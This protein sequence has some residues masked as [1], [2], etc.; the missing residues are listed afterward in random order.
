MPAEFHFLRP[1]WFFALPLILLIWPL[2]R[3]AIQSATSWERAIDPRLLAH[4]LDRASARPSKAPLWLIPPAW[5][6]AITALAGPVWQQLPQPVQE[7]QD[8]LVILLDL[9]LSMLATDVQ[10]NRLTAARRKLR[11]L[12]ET[13]D[14]G[15]TGLIVYAGDP[16]TVS[17]LSD[18]ANTIVNMLPALDPSIMPVPGSRL[19]P[20]ISLASEL[21]RGGGAQTGRI[22]VMTDEIRDVVDAA[23]ATGGHAISVLGIGTAT[24]API[25]LAEGDLKDNQGVMV[26]PT[27]DPS[28]LRRFVD[29]TGGRFATMTLGDADL[30]YLLA[31]NDVIDDSFRDIDRDF[32]VWLEEGPWL[33][34]LVLPLAALAFRRGWVWCAVLLL[35][36]ALAPQPASAFEWADLWQRA[37]QRGAEQLAAGDAEAAAATFDDPDWRAAARYRAGD[38]ETAAGEFARADTAT[39][40]YNSGNA[41]ARLGKLDEALTAYDATLAAEPEHEDSRFNRDL[42]AQLLNQQQQQQ[43]PS[44]GGDEQ[45]QQTQDQQQGEQ[46]SGESE[47]GEQQNAGSDA[48]QDGEQGGQEQQAAEHAGGE[49]EQHA[50]PESLDAGEEE[51]AQQASAE[52]A[53]QQETETEG[54]QQ[55]AL[56]QL[57]SEEAEA[58]QALRQW[59]QRVPDD[60]GG[61]LRAKFRR[62]SAERN[63]SGRAGQPDAAW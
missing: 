34:L 10:P 36:L 41:L 51:Q 40:H 53:E 43:N 8:A 9:S 3:L 33:V 48:E 13:R 55:A 7:K 1:E 62:K 59:L 44:D 25:P 37:D 4:L 60:P 61:L 35:P 26:I 39:G 54:E 30:D 56:A 11:D 6:L 22:L 15:V 31:P 5:L 16:H 52:T 28:P 50:S 46:N 23:A 63:Q 17:P 45:Q 38:F 20:A 2:A 19:A 47:Q 32:D 14:E 21:F 57:D 12:L 58:E 42:V 27:L 49:Q 18:D 24:G 29:D